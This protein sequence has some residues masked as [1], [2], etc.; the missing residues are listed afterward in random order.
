M[1]S[2]PLCTTENQSLQSMNVWRAYAF[3][4]VPDLF[5]GSNYFPVY[6]CSIFYFNEVTISP[7]FFYFHLKFLIGYFTMYIT[8]EGILETPSSQCL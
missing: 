6:V 3:P 1:L 2:D 7:I 4:L 8:D 5:S